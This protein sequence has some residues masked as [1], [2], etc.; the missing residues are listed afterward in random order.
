MSYARN[1]CRIDARLAACASLAILA[2]CGGSADDG[3]TSEAAATA[4]AAPPAP[5]RVAA[6]PP[7]LARTH[8]RPALPNPLP[9]VNES[10]G[11]A[12][13]RP[14]GSIDP[15]GPVFHSPGTNGPNCSS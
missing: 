14:A 1:W 13:Y 9:A 6:G 10:G 8:P 3:A 7:T 2:A 11:A 4:V 5:E 12:T 15:T